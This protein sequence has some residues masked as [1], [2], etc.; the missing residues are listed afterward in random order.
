MKNVLIYL[1]AFG[2]LVTS[3]SSITAT[4]PVSSV[5]YLIAT[6]IQ[7]SVVLVLLWFSPYFVGI[8]S[9]ILNKITIL[10]TFFYDFNFNTAQATLA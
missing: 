4:N 5:V 6:F 8:S 2:A 1:L 9:I 3:V 7:F 10:Y